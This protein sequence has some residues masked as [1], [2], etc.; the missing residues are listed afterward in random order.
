MCALPSIAP[1]HLR[2][3]CA[4]L[5]HEAGGELEQI[6]FLL[7]QSVFRR[8]SDTWAVSSGFGMLSTIGLGLSHST[9]RG[10]PPWVSGTRS[11]VIE[12]QQISNLVSGSLSAEPEAYSPK[13]RLPQGESAELMSNETVAGPFG[14][15]PSTRYDSPRRRRRLHK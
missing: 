1:H 5:C 9:H 15:F 3:T 11:A 14:G 10:D 6:Q 8:P 4:R 2:R 12:N 7:G 13:F